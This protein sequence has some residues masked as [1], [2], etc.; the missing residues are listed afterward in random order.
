MSLALGST[1]FY[2]LGFGE[3][4]PI[5]SEHNRGM[6]VLLEKINQLFNDSSIN[7]KRPISKEDIVRISIL[8]RPNSGKST[9]TNYFLNETRQIVAEEAGITKDSI[10]FPF[11]YK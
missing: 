3:P 4:L 2:S 6:D 5:S 11:L 7:K 1:E 10:S 8:G 9:L